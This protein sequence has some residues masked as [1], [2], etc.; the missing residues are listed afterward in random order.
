MFMFSIINII[1]RIIVIINI[2]LLL[3]LLLLFII[4]II[5]V[6]LLL[7]IIIMSRGIGNGS[8]MIFYAAIYNDPTV[9]YS[10]FIKGGCSGNRV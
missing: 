8:R 1:I 4:I 7:L 5:I 10:R 6:L 2:I 9:V 3:L